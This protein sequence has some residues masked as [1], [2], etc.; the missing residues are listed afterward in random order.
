MGFLDQRRVERPLQRALAAS[1]PDDPAIA[2][3]FKRLQRRP[4]AA[5]AGLLARIQVS[6]NRNE[7]LRA[8]RVLYWLLD[9]DTLRHVVRGLESPTQ[10][11]VQATTAVLKVSD[12]YNPNQLLPLLEG[13]G[14]S[15]SAVLEI[16]EKHTERV[17]PAKLVAVADTLPPTDLPALFRILDQTVTPDQLEYLIRKCDSG[18]PH[19]RRHVALLLRHF[20]RAEA[21]GALEGLLLDPDAEVRLAALESLEKIDAPVHISAFIPLLY[22]S[23]VSIQ[24]QAIDSV[25]SRH[26]G[27][28]TLKLLLPL[29]M[30]ESAYVR[31]AA[32]EVLNEIA[33]DRMI[34]VL[35]TT[36]NDED[37]WSRERA[38]DALAKVGGPRVATAMI[39]LITADDELSRR[40]AVEVINTTRDERARE[41]LVGALQDSDWW[42]KERAIDALAVMGGKH[43]LKVLREV[44]EQDPAARPTTLRAL[45]V[46]GDQAALDTIFPYLRDAETMVRVEALRA[47]ETLAG[48]DHADRAMTGIEEALGDTTEQRFRNEAK[49]VLR[50]LQVRSSSGDWEHALDDFDVMSTVARPALPAQQMGEAD[51]L[52]LRGLEVGTVFDDRYRFIAWIG[53]GAFGEVLHFEDL[54]VDEEIVIKFL[55]SRVARDETT[56]ARFVQELRF[57]RR[58]THPNVIRIY[59]F[60]RL[61][62]E[63]AISMEYFDGYPLTQEFVQGRPMRVDRVLRLLREIAFGMEAAH[64]S[65]VVHRDLK[66]G[67]I[68]MNPLGEVKIVDFGI[69]AAAHAED[70]PEMTVAG[71]FVGT[72]AYAAPEQIRG[73]TIDA[74]TDIY[75]LGIVAYRMLTGSLPYNEK[76]SSAMV[77]RHLKGDAQ[78]VRTLNPKAD[79]GLSALV[80]RMMEVD[81]DARWPSMAALRDAIE[82][83][84]G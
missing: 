19:L 62:G 9:R 27:L 11:V 36:L 34:G 45:A 42:V 41:H 82:R 8:Q 2:K 44:L 57:A 20:P 55:R 47:I 58:V 84:I 74:R 7:I 23:N 35:I 25:A 75:S 15:K 71:R 61:A 10:Q 39:G 16:L 29:L 52:D 5:V 14:A 21:T 66:P 49:R 28:D 59:D 17:N 81:P 78:P 77:S 65:G 18:N 12:A 32:V 40:T 26:T 67:N 70:D 69:A 50:A 56:K 4:D 24:N 63:F 6:D 37:W 33:D 3:D 31:R 48:E 38:T 46:L 68:L 79:P 76:S 83:L 51:M 1:S 13:G 80:G 64:R 73:E 22:D 43:S 53:S 72:P 30:E 54:A 60:I